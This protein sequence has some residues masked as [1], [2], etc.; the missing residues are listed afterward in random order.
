MTLAPIIVFA[1]NRADHLSRTLD[2]LSHNK[3][4]ADSMLYIFCD[5]P[6]P[7]CTAEQ[8]AKLQAARE[9]VK[10]MA[11]TPAF[12]EVHVIER[13]ENYG[14]GKSII[15]GVTEIIN[16]YG[17]AIIVEDDLLT[18]PAFLTYMNACLEHYANRKSVF[19]VTALSRPNPER[20]FPHDYPYDVY[21][22]LK[23]HPWGWATWAD[24]WSQVDW[25][26]EAY[27]TIKNNP[28]MYQA[29]CRMG[30]DEWEELEMQRSGN[31]NIWSARFALAHFVNHA[32]S[33]AP[34]EPYVRNIGDDTDASNCSAL[35]RWYIDEVCENYSPHLLDVLY[36]DPRI[37]NTWYS[38]FKKGKRSLFGKLKNWFGR[39]FLHRDEYAL[40]G[41]VYA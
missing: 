38:F 41:K 23:H 3:L 17:K 36:E 4:A 10:N 1:Y 35:G 16:R 37:I 2:A 32:V 22:S 18:S 34:I 31:K 40:K 20:F 21:C 6:K 11:V 15:M 30:E 26:A 25:S 7:G 8:L 33:I 13:T 9:V 24:R 12:K 27:D 39:K 14:L 28:I 5:G 19:S 29:F